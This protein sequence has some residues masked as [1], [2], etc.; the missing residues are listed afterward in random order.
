[1]YTQDQMLIVELLD[2][3]QSSQGSHS[4][5]LIFLQKVHNNLWT[6]LQLAKAGAAAQKSPETK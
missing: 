4:G 3:Y 1:M 6:L 5:R 2:E